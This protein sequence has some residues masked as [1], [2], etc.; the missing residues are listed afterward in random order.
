M[1]KQARRS[2]VA[3]ACFAL[4]VF[5]AAF[6]PSA[7]AASDL[8]DALA[9]AVASQTSVSSANASAVNQNTTTQNAT[10]VQ[11]G[12][13]DGSGQSQSVTQLAPTVQSAT[14]TSASA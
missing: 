4:L 12:G 6:Y 8:G 11:N 5:G 2:L 1:R 3:L 9:G 10:V 7:A 14:A 13:G